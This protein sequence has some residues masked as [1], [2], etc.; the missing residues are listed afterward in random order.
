MEYILDNLY[1][2]KIFG[3]ASLV[4]ILTI[5]EKLVFHRIYPKVKASARIWDD[6]LIYALHFPL[7]L[8]IWLSGFVCSIAIVEQTFMEIQF[9]VAPW[10]GTFHKLGAF[11]L[12]IWT[13]LRFINKF[14]SKLFFIHSVKHDP[15]RVQGIAHVLRVI[16]FSF[17]ALGMLQF[18]GIPLSGIIA[19]GGIGGIAV[20][21]AAK[22]LLANFF[23]GLMI[24]L[25]RQFKVGDWIRSPDK[26]IEGTVEHIGWRLTRIR[27]FDKRP[28]FV[29]NSI[30]STIAIEN[31]SRM[32]NRRIK[33]TIGLSY[34]DAPKIASI[35]SDIEH[36]LKS[37]PEVD[38]TSICFVNLVDFGPYSLDVM[39][40]AFTKTT[41]WI[42]FQ[43]VQQDVFLKILEV[44]TNH[45]S[46]IAYPI[47]SIKLP[48]SNSN[49]NVFAKKD[50]Y[51]S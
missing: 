11:L 31:P 46:K 10:I 40:Y 25:D 16:V 2:I 7:K 50:D 28:L 1:L 4:L 42:K 6:A 3:I 5:T 8:Y 29:P 21:F 34:E 17:G 30:F 43:A 15:T 26:E 12:L 47:R 27:T 51:Q 37:H 39:V 22:D 38:A 18:L 23:G 14:E 13:F 49:K 36:M 41:N 19:F 20:G 45:N 35:L 33:A 32:S 24:F 44:I 48:E 9:K